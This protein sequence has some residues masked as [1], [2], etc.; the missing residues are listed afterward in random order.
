MQELQQSRAARERRVEAIERAGL[1]AI[2]VF[3]PITPALP[4]PR[5]LRLPRG[6]YLSPFLSRHGRDVW[7]AVDSRHRCRKSL[8]VTDQRPEDLCRRVLLTLLDQIDPVVQLR[9]I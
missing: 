3:A 6:V 4:H 2:D 9:A 1:A 8:E 7:F 5:A